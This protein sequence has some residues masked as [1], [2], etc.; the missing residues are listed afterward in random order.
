MKKKKQAPQKTAAKTPAKRKD[1]PYA[2]LALILFLTFLVYRSSTGN[3]FVLWDDDKYIQNNALITSINLKEIFST[4]VMGNYHPFT[5][6]GYAIQYQFFGQDATGYHVVNLML[7]L[8]NV[9]LV[10]FV[11]LKLSNKSLVA[12]VA[13]L[14]FG[15]HPMHVESVAWASELKDL[16][17]ASFYLGAFICYL[18]YGNEPLK[19]KWYYYA[20]VL[21]LCSLLSK[22]M[23]VSLPLVLLLTDYFRGRKFDSKILVEKLP[24]FLLSIVFGIIAVLAQKSL[25]ATESTVF[26]LPQRVIFASYA[27][28]TYLVKIIVPIQLSTYYPYPVKPGEALPMLYYVYPVVVLAA[29]AIA[30]YYFRRT[31]KKIIFGLGLFIA[32]ILLVLQLLPVGDTVMADRYTYLPSIGIFFLAGEGFYWLWNRNKKLLS[33]ALAAVFLIFFSIQTLAR[34]RVWE[35]GLTL[36]NDVIAQYKNVPAAFYNRGI[37][38][39]NQNQDAEALSD[40]NSAIALKPDYADAYNNRGSLYLRQG[41]TEAALKDLNKAVSL[42]AR[43]AQGYFNR[44]YILYQKQQYKEALSD[45]NQVIALKPDPA[46]LV[47]VYNLRGLLYMAEKNHPA[48]LADFNTAIQMKPD[49][50][51]AYNNRGS[52]WVAQGNYL[53]AVKDFT[54]AIVLKNDYAE[55]YFNRGIAEYNGGNKNAG[56]KDWQHASGLGYQAATQAYQMN[57]R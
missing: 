27:F 20:L 4:Y 36:W 54:A 11:I 31:S 56:C 40:F 55:A 32:T 30:G 46:Q 53:E 47:I 52:L 17:Y 41:K 2:G 34:C 49:F 28:I 3:G 50:V 35:N 16:L 10:Y 22:G 23:A 57:C 14:F 42:N 6:L 7:H 8:L 43:L 19:K 51:Q 18:K 45:Y 26:P 12:L 44:A 24:F 15:L 37:Y 33:L 48:A 25:G 21:F 29:L 1:Y 39:F 13:A 38:F 9:V 5:M